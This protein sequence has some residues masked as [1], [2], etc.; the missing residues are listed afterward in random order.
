MVKSIY[1]LL[2]N[3]IMEAEV[4]M[5]KILEKLSCRDLEILNIIQKK[6]L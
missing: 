2:K 6:D 4:Y 1:T 3:L 5:I